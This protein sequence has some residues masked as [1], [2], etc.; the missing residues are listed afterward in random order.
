MSE[1]YEE[2]EIQVVE[3]SDQSKVKQVLDEA[4]ID[5]VSA[6]PVSSSVAYL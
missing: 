5:S 6:T 3:V 1:E 4:I 2:V